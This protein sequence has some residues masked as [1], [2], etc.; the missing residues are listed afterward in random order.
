MEIGRGSLEKWQSHEDRKQFAHSGVS[1][2][3]A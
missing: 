3:Q 2:D 1:S